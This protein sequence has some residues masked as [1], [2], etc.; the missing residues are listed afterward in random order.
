MTA[1]RRRVDFRLSA[2]MRW[3]AEHRPSFEELAAEDAV[4]SR[5][6]QGLP[7]RVTDPSLVS[8]LATLFRGAP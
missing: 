6:A 1:Q 8:R 3:P 7:D 2:M 5:R 4:L